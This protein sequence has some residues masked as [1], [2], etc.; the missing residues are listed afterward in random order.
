MCDECTMTNKPFNEAV[1][2]TLKDLRSSNQL[3]RGVMF[4][5]AVNFKHTLLVVTKG[6]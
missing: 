4:L 6:T 1:N 3:F 5:C 2:R